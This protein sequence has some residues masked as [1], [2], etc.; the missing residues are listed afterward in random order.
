VAAA[1]RA[2]MPVRHHAVLRSKGARLPVKRP[3]GLLCSPMFNT[4][5]ARQAATPPRTACMPQTRAKLPSCEAGQLKIVVV[6]S[7]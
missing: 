6:L 4:S 2:G 5:T 3:L 7:W 1:D